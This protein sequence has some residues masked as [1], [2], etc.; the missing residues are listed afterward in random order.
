MACLVCDHTMQCLG[1][2]KGI[3]RFWCSRCG[4]LKDEV[5]SRR[6]EDYGLPSYESWESP[7]WTRLMVNAEWHEVKEEVCHAI[8]LQ[9]VRSELKNPEIVP[10]TYADNAVEERRCK[11]SSPPPTS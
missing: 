5:P 4:T 6:D 11:A 2:D 7:R 8:E 9:K 3:K 1:E 10:G